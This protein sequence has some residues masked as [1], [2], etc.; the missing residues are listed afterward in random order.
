MSFSPQLLRT[1][2]LDAMPSGA[3][4]DLCVAF[5]GG[6]DSTALVLALAELRAA[7][8]ELQVRA[9]H[10]DHQ[11]QANSASWAAH[12]DEL[13][14]SLGVVCE[15]VTVDV[16]AHSA[17]GIE[18]AARAA[19]YAVLRD[20]LRPRELLLTAHHADDQ[21]ET[22]L[23]A[24][25]RGAGLR[26]LASMP[27]LQ[28]FGSGWHMRP[29]LP[30]TRN[31]IEHWIRT[32]SKTWID[33][34]TN[35]D[36]RFDRNLLRSEIVPRLRRRWP[37]IAQT[38]SRTVQHIAEADRLLDDLARL[39]MTSAAAGP[40]LRM[41]A[42]MSL[43]SPRR[44]NLMRYWLRDRGL[45]APSLL[46]LAALEH[47]L[48]HAADDR[49]PGTQWDGMQ[50]RRYRGL[51]YADVALPPDASVLQPLTWDWRVPLELG[52]GLGRIVLQTDRI[53]GLDE[54]R[55]PARLSVV[56]DRD[57]L[58]LPAHDGMHHRKL[59]KVL[60]E[61]GVLPWWRHCLPM[62]RNESALI[63]VGDLWIA[64]ELAA[65]GEG[66]RMRIV[67]EDRPAILAQRE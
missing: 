31:A 40:C 35:D 49:Q 44:R 23:L 64:E 41:S 20:L 60:Q 12:C 10:V 32:Q 53:Q 42:L 55:M 17:E 47:D 58:R 18:S 26:G 59:K 27:A 8:P 65:S 54:S 21:L 36:A 9:I 66:G 2:I 19:R 14:H 61:A 52:H 29:M 38:A 5:S 4:G 30:F 1:Q 51:L 37:A 67:W 25:A 33:D 3:S 48:L 62:I 15:T 7:T 45:R 34:P 56:F 46:K 16:D 24:L 28:P 57:G 50:V 43:S 63:A 39:D 13:A 22:V 6:M 11:L